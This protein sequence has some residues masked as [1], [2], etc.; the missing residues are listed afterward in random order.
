[1]SREF[2]AG[3]SVEDAPS[4]AKLHEIPSDELPSRAFPAV[5]LFGCRIST[6]EVSDS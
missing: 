1:V 2:R 4:P 6:D 5:W 3:G